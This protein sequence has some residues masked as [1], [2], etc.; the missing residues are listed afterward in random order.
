MRY[1]STV[2]KYVSPAF[3]NDMLRIK[4]DLAILPE[5]N[6]QDILD[7]LSDEEKYVLLSLY[8]TESRQSF[9]EL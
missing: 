5:I 1:V 6:V 3:I 4:K 7:H 8:I 9:T 2:L